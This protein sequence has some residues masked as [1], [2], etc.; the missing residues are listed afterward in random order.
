MADWSRLPE[1]ILDRVA[2]EPTTGCWLLVAGGVKGY[3]TSFHDGKSWRSHRLSYTLLVGPIPPGLEI[4][5]LCRNRM[6]INPDH[7]EPTT[8]R[9]NVLRGNGHTARNHRKTH[10][11]RGHELANANLYIDRRGR[12]K[13][14]ACERLHD[15]ALRAR[16]NA[17]RTGPRG[18]MKLSAE[19]RIAKA[20]KAAAAR[21]RKA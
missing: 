8:T 15:A 13:C 9:E 10:C 11:V 12:R 17:A 2:F 18:H 21:W 6:C 1:R 3:C 7:L 16:R 5:H 19:Q 20:K 4:D 14:R